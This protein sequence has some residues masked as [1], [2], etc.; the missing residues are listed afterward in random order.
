[1]KIQSDLNKQSEWCERNILFLNV[2]K[3]KTITFSRI[4][5]LVEFSYMLGGTVLYRVSSINDLE[6]IMDKKM[7]FLEHID[8]MV[9][10]A[11]AMLGFIRSLS[12]EFRDPYTL[13]SLFSSAVYEAHSMTCMWTRLNVCRE[14]LSD[15]L[16][17]VWVGR[18]FTICHRMSI[19]VLFCALTLL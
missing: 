8:I 3:C 1:M 15:M 6:V 10:K 16:C 17:V 7:N 14:G 13:K 4:R 18:I 9:G 19:G 12:L 2:D 5:Y 11:F